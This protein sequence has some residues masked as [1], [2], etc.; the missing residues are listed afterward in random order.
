[1]AAARAGEWELAAA[2]LAGQLGDAGAQAALV[3]AC[4]RAVQWQRAL[5]LLAAWRAPGRPPD[6]RVHSAAARALSGAT[7]WAQALALV[8]QLAAAGLRP[9]ATCRNVLAEA[10]RRSG[11]WRQAVSGLARSAEDAGADAIGAVAAVESCEAAGAPAG[12][13]GRALR[14]A[15]R[16]ALEWATSAGVGA[17]DASAEAARGVALCSRAWE[18][19]SRGVEAGWVRLG[20]AALR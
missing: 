1:M 5:A 12:V 20:G 2:L 17:S 3:S 10:Y 16:R 14:M 6:G 7:C 8:A 18:A 13:L 4:A 15:R 11:R 9:D 19:H